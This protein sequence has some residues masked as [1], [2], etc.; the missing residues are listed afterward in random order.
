MKKII[1]QISII[2]LALSI[3]GCGK[4]EDNEKAVNPPQLLGI[5]VTVNSTSITKGFKVIGHAI[6]YFD[7][8]TT[9]DVTTQTIWTSS[10]TSVLKHFFNENFSSVGVGTAI[11]SAEFAG[12]EVNTTISVIDADLLSL[13]IGIEKSTLAKGQTTQFSAVGKYSDN[14]EV[15]I[16]NEVTWVSGNNVTLPIDSNGTAKSYFEG[17]VYVYAMLNSVQ[18]NTI[19]VQIGSPILESIKLTQ[20]SNEILE[21][22]GTQ[23]SA[24]GV[25]SDST[26]VDITSNVSW[27]S[28]N[29]LIASVQSDGYVTGVNPGTVY[30]RASKGAV[31]SDINLTVTKATLVSINLSLPSNVE[32]GWT[33]DL[34]ATGVYENNITKDISQSVTWKSNDSNIATVSNNTVTGV[35]VGTVSLTATQNNITSSD[36]ID[37]IDEIWSNHLYVSKGSSSTVNIDGTIQS[38]SWKYFILNNQVK[39]NP[40]SL[41]A[42]QLLGVDGN[43]NYFLNQTLSDDL[44]FSE[45]IVYK[46][47]LSADIY[48][49]KV[50]YVVQDINKGTEYTFFASW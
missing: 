2:L 39:A 46:V 34:N 42:V 48:K 26:A 5:N 19:I 23:F 14:S 29:S 8:N 30:I 16:T 17:T 10:D 41:R 45:D 28:G 25:Y 18:S 37:V 4:S 1:Y 40:S 7:N 6:A 12:Y 24:T 11:V 43:G 21:G 22:F 13:N 27:S 44:V 3:I 31:F 15:D 49:P 33:K 32:I 47:S 38:G 35:S 50:G 36:S 20:E 9:K